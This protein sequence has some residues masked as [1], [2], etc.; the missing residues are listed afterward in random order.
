MELS[1]HPVVI[2][3]IVLGVL[4]GTVAAVA[5]RP[6]LPAPTPIKH[7]YA[8]PAREH[9]I[10]VEVLNTTTRP[11]LARSATRVLRRQSLDVVFFG[12]ADGSAKVDSTQV[13]ARR[14][15]RGAAQTVA[16]V[17]G[18]GVV[19]LQTDTLRRVDVTVLL[20]SDYRPP[21]DGHP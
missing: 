18:Q 2:A 19:K 8:V 17:L 4:G 7:A 5:L 20:G 6:P 11:G 12:N 13:I 16:K 15:N 9:R 21:V 14:G 1:R 3:L 10:L